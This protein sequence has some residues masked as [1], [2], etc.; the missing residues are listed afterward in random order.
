[1]NKLFC[2]ILIGATFYG[3]LTGMVQVHI[4]PIVTQLQGEVVHQSGLLEEQR[5]YVK[6]EQLIQTICSAHV[7]AMVSA[8]YGNI[9]L[10]NALTAI[11]AT[12][13]QQHEAD[14][15]AF[16]AEVE[17]QDLGENH[18]AIPT[19]DRTFQKKLCRYIQ[20]RIEAILIE[21]SQPVAKDEQVCQSLSRDKCESEIQKLVKA[22]LPLCDV[23]RIIR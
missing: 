13:Y 5:N 2:S 6:T 1:M 14:D 9:P 17:E 22:R 23:S 21:V 3:P 10:E 11:D 19:I 16:L 18:F 4:E 8:I 12:R 15:E 7:R 20:G